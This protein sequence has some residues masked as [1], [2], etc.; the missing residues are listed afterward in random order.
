MTICSGGV[1]NMLIPSGNSNNDNARNSFKRIPPVLT[2]QYAYSNWNYDLSI[3]EAFSLLE[4]E[5][6][7]LA[8]FLSLTVQDKQAVRTVRVEN[9]SL[10]NGVK[11]IMEELDK[12]YLN[13]ENSQAYEAYKNLKNSQGLM[14]YL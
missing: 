1:C 4:K 5:K 8:V 7:G 12:L 3:L 13:G 11:L 14:K 9:L 2:K 6:R 10:A